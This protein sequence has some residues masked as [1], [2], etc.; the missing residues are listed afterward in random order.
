V[1]IITSFTLIAIGLLQ[2][3]A[4]AGTIA[5]FLPGS[6]AKNYTLRIKIRIFHIPM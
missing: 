6:M 4:A 2:S 3:A 1:G 5:S